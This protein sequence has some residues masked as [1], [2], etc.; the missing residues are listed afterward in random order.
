MILLAYGESRIGLGWGTQLHIINWQW[1][2]GFLKTQEHPETLLKN[3]FIKYVFT[4]ANHIEDASDLLEN[5][6]CYN[7]L[8]RKPPALSANDFK[9]YGCNLDLESL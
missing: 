7:Y 9:T 5:I 2:C 4:V 1:L 8:R 6:G 3:A